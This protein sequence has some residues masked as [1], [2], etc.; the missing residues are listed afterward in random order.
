[1]H[2]SEN[3]DGSEESKAVEEESGSTLKRLEVWVDDRRLRQ[4]MMSVW[5][6]GCKGL[7][8]RALVNLIHTYTRSGDPFVRKV[9][10][11]LL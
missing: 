4:R 7:Y 10:D 6:E 3:G 11:E 8:G 1:M 2:L 5:I 9:T